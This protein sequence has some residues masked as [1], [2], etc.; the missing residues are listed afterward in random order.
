MSQHAGLVVS[1][2]SRLLPARSVVCLDVGDVTLWAALA[3][4]LDKPGQVRA[5]R[6]TGRTAVERR[7]PM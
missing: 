2:L 4:C 3:L 1:R 6:R 7:P 5:R